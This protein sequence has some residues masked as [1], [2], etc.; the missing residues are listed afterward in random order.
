MGYDDGDIDKW[1]E[2]ASV[3]FQNFREQFMQTYYSEY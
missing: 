3:G 2:N 1:E